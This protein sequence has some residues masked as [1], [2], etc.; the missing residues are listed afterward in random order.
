MNFESIVGRF[1]DL[2]DPERPAKDPPPAQL[3]PFFRW[4]LSGTWP[5][6][7]LCVFGYAVG[8][9][10]EALMMLLLGKVVDAT[11]VGP[12]AFWTLNAG[13]LLG[14]AILLLVFR[15]IAFGLASA[16]QTI[17]LS[18]NL[19][20]QVLVRLNRHT[21][22]QSVTFFDDDFAGR[23]AQK[24]MQTS[25]AVVDVVAETVNAAVFAMSSAL[26]ML[27]LTGAVDLGMALILVAWLASYV[28][29]LT[30]FLPRIR[31]RSTD[32]AAKRA[33][34]TGQ[35]VDTVTNIKTVKLFAHDQ[36]EDR[37][38]LDAIGRYRVSATDWAGLAVL[39]RF[40]LILVRRCTAG[41]AAGVRIDTVDSRGCQLRRV[42][43]DRCDVDPP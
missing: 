25:R 4:S 26:G 29:I 30:Y 31:T 14:S 41:A 9:A 40:T 42:G 1:S 3:W 11:I 16:F 20:N 36:F 28:L 39:F 18:P 8:G 17:T 23:I 12:Q 13:L 27:A 43:G 2:I 33:H 35:I 22:G 34:V 32:R 10:S 7:W 6:I 15:P 37:A 19:F 5:V 24:Q 38:A 21:L